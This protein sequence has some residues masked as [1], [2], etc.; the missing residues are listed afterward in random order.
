MN[1]NDSIRETWDPIL[2]V[3]IQEHA[4]LQH[5]FCALAILS[6]QQKKPSM[7]VSTNYVDAY[8]LHVH[9]LGNFRC[10]VEVAGKVDWVPTVMFAMAVIVIEVRG[11]VNQLD[12]ESLLNMLTTI[13]SSARLVASV[14]AGFM[15]E[16]RRSQQQR[17][18]AD[19]QHNPEIQASAIK[20]RLEELDRAINAVSVE[21]DLDRH[22][23]QSISALRKWLVDTQCQ[24]RTWGHLIWWPASLTDEFLDAV[25]RGRPLA[26]LLYYFWAAALGDGLQGWFFGGWVDS[27]LPFLKETSLS[28]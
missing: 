24:P 8:R 18:A 17:L 9:A 26:L 27:V 6:S 22:Y 1:E 11:L 12:T 25:K 15:Q 28:V 4:F 14:A 10:H 3:Q 5:A 21:S 7:S 19:R 23:Q 20:Q 2:S 13:R 16:R